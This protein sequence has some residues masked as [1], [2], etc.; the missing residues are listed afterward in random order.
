MRIPG[1]LPHLNWYLRHGNVSWRSALSRRDPA[2]FGFKLLETTNHKGKDIDPSGHS[3]SGKA[4]LGYHRI[5][6]PGQCPAAM[7]HPEGST[8]AAG[9]EAAA[10]VHLPERTLT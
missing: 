7:A 10:P 1:R 4:Q 9:T 8:D 3:R 5:L 2:T 6:A